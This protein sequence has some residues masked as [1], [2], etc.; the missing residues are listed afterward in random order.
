[1]VREYLGLPEE[2][3]ALSFQSRLAGD[4]WLKP[5]TDF[6]FKRLA[7]EG[8]TK[9]AVITPAFVSDCLETL[10]E[11]AMEGEEDFMEAGGE[12][13]KHI[14][15]LNDSDPWVALMKDWVTQWET[16]GQI[17]YS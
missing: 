14:S 4:R 13:F 5:Y 7:K 17:P 3:V 6:E 11:I 8:K 15:C 9:L 1:M 10:E 16:S 2:Q 12:A